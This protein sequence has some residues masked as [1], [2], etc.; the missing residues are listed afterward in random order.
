MELLTPSFGPGII[1]LFA[2]FIIYVMYRKLTTS[3]LVIALL[4]GVLVYFGTGINGI[5]LLFAFFSLAVLATSH[6]K[7]LKAAI[8][9]DGRHPQ[10]RT[11][12]QVFANGGVAGI[13]AGLALIDK[14]HPALY[15][16]MLAGSLASALADTWSSELGTVYG[17]NFYNI[18]T[19]KKEPRGLD[20][21]VSLEGTAIGAAGAAIIA[22]LYGGFHTESLI[23]LAAGLLG[24]LTDSLLGA[25]LERKQLI[26]NDAVNF[27]NTLSAA[28]IGLVLYFCW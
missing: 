5:I 12:G 21:V 6:K 14:E 19:F 17:R 18:L 28:L 4:I 8:S 23:V 15:H 27:L 3:A 2:L 20:G 10:R 1:L 11:A 25:A 7:D 24:N 13:V 9:S 16:L 22:L 26:S